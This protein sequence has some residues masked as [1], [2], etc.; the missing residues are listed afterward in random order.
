MNFVNSMANWSQEEIRK[1]NNSFVEPHCYDSS[2]STDI[3]KQ[4]KIK[5]ELKNN[6]L[7]EAGIYT[8][9]MIDKYFNIIKINASDY[10]YV[11]FYKTM[12]FCLVLL[13]IEPTKKSSE[14]LL[15]AY[16]KLI[17]TIWP[18]ITLL[19]HSIRGFPDLEIDSD[20]DDIKDND[21]TMELYHSAAIIKTNKTNNAIEIRTGKKFNL[22]VLDIDNVYLAFDLF[23]LCHETA[24][25]IT[26]TKKYHCYYKYCDKLKNDIKQNLGYDI[27]NNT[28]VTASPSFYEY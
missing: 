22:T 10:E 3:E 20:D 24:G 6:I 5:K 12:D 7:N 13:Y 23:V 2:E 9:A 18:S 17:K 4:I 28:N 27:K 8:H 19:Q 14:R 16:K 15:I 26:K 11:N 21:K 25:R 1:Y